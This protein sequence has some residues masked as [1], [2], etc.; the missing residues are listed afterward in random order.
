M[1]SAVRWPSH[2][3]AYPD[4][5]VGVVLVD[6]AIPGPDPWGDV[7]SNPKVWRLAFHSFPN[8]PETTVRG[9]ERGYFDFLYEAV[10]AHP[11]SIDDDAPS[12]HTSPPAR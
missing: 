2:L 6:T 1:T 8:L 10:N 9:R 4:E 7:I 11:E 12:W 5:I 3:V